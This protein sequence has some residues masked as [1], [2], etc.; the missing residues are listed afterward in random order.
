MR[1]I[2]VRESISIDRPARDIYRFWRK[3]EN[4]PRF[5]DHLGSVENLGGGRHRWTISTPFGRVI[6]ESEITEDR[7]NEV[8]RW[9]SL[10]GSGVK[11][12]GVLSLAER[13]GAGAAVATVE[14]HYKPP[15]GFDS[16]FLE[17]ILEVVTDE[18]I[19][20]SL[21]KLKHLMESQAA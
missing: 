8:I 3:L 11:N 18:A 1:E 9:R 19:R 10:P 14:L 21:T 16:F 2:H 13:K 5:I 6:W 17:P 7:E 20:E 4:L 15:R 12:S